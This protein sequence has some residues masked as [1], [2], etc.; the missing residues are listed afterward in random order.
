MEVAVPLTKQELAGAVSASREMVQRELKALR[1]R[2]V[3][4]TGRRRL[5]IVRP[6]VLHRIARDRPPTD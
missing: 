3:I 4:N 5:V 6:D 2:G 1:D